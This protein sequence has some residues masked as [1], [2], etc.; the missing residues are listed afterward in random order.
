MPLPR[1][2]DRY[3]LRCQRKWEGATP[4]SPVVKQKRVEKS[5]PDVEKESVKCLWGRQKGKSSIGC[6]GSACP[7]VGSWWTV[8]H[9]SDRT[10][11]AGKVRCSEGQAQEFPSWH[12][13]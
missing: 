6:L 8:V 4:L 13:G 5:T 10:S 11:L 2:K 12:S 1:E 3:H 7:C 9:G